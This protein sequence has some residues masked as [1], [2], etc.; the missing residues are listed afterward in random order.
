MKIYEMTNRP[1]PDMD[2]HK[3]LFTPI[4]YAAAESQG[5]VQW[6]IERFGSADLVRGLGCHCGSRYVY[7]DALNF[8]F[9]DDEDAF[10]FR[11]RWC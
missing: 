3:F 7:S 8:W 9:R 10:Q 1:H 11:L 5:V 4:D 2:G 6:A